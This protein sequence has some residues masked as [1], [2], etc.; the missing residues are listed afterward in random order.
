MSGNQLGLRLDSHQSIYW[1][2]LAA[3]LISCIGLTS[4]GIW[5]FFNILSGNG[6][7]SAVIFTG[8]TPNRLFLNLTYLIVLIF[9]LIWLTRIPSKTYRFSEVIKLSAPFLLL[10]YLAYP[11]SSDFY[12]YLQYGWMSLHK[13][14]PYLHPAANFTSILTP[15]ID[16]SEQTSTYGPL[17]MG[18]MVI[19]ALGLFAHPFAA[20][21]LL[22]FFCLLFHIINA[23]LIWHF[24]GQSPNRSKLTL[25]YILNP[26]IVSAFIADVHVDVFLCTSIL[27]LIGCLYQRRYVLSILAVFAGFLTKTLPIIWIPLV[28]MF[29]VMRR[30]WKELGI[31]TSIVLLIVIILSEH[32]LPTLSAWVGLL[33][34]STEART[35]RSIHHIINVVANQF[36]G[37]PY[38]QNARIQYGVKL[39]GY[40]VFF[41]AYFVILS[42]ILLS[43]RYAETDLV[44][45]I[46]WV[47]LILLLFAT[48]WSMPW[49][50]SIL[51]PMALLSIDAP[52]FTFAALVFCLCPTLVCGAALGFNMFGVITALTTFVPAVLGIVLGQKLFPYSGL[53]D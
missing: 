49:Y 35:A 5:N 31:A 48:P 44:R 41:G 19:S 6:N 47:T 20:L 53:A 22:K 24:L 14:N 39:I 42:K 28:V 29:L 23:F 16:W 11:L 38:E 13:I 1:G 43:R 26:A 51:L 21:Y 33:N 32:V 7:V 2:G 18:L 3:T 4:L 36:L 40:A 34:P 15:Y 27:L 52:R 12:L 10:A 9:Y 46:G 8:F 30:R 17:S 45:D 25:A 37:L 50:P